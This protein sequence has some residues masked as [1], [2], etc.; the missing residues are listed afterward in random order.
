[1]VGT[2]RKRP[3]LCNAPQRPLSKKNYV[4]T[5]WPVPEERLKRGVVDHDRFESVSF[6]GRASL[7]GASFAAE[8][9]LEIVGATFPLRAPCRRSRRARALC[10]GRTNMQGKT[11][12]PAAA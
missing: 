2:F 12:A 5:V 3:I 4:S 9:L 1:M 10:P 8:L 6:C 11:E 7:T